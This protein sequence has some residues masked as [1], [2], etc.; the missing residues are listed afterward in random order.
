MGAR[1]TTLPGPKGTQTISTGSNTVL[2]G[3]LGTLI[4]MNVIS[5]MTFIVKVRHPS[6]VKYDLCLF[7]YHYLI[8]TLSY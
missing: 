8:Y 7:S 2:M 4:G 1:G 3:T 5:G 6:C